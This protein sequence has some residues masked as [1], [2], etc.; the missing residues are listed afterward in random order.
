LFI[1]V[2]GYVS[3]RLYLHYTVHKEMKRILMTPI[4]EE[5]ERLDGKNE[6]WDD[7]SYA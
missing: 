4:S 1:I 3:W 2:F 6:R 7:D 5:L